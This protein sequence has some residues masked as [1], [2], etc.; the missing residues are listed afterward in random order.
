MH[1]QKVL[2]Q[3]YH[4]AEG[5][6]YNWRSNEED[7]VKWWL[8]QSEQMDNLQTIEGERIIVLDAGQRNDG[9]GPDIFRSRII[10]DDLEMSGHV[11]M[12][13][14]AEDW[15]RHGHQN[16]VRYDDVM[17]HV[18]VG[19]H[20]GPDIPTLLVERHRLGA[21]QCIA[22]RRI[23]KKELMGYSFARFKHKEEHVRLLSEVGSGHNPLFLGMIEIIMAGASRTRQLHNAA[24]ILGMENWPDCRD[25][26]GSN[27]SFP[28]EQSR[29]VLFQ[30]MMRNA[31]LFESNLW[32]TIPENSWFDWNTRYSLFCKIG[33]PVN[34]FREWLVNILAPS[35]GEQQGF[36]LWQRMQIFRHYGLEKKMLQQLGLSKISS[37]AEQQGLLSWKNIFCSTG[38]C[39]KC[40]LTQYHHTLTH[41]N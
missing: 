32:Q 1:Y 5:S 33:L 38:S 13:L 15:F 29:S 9:P 8:R 21:S 16:D 36:E 7:L 27:L 2:L 34:Q 41:I 11:E 28:K 25:W 12:H 35:M 26:K 4:I 6:M 19:G 30:E 3:Q 40:P 24:L 20:G 14:R 17:L 31:H 37:V 23:S 39:V 22:Q 18:I 10:L